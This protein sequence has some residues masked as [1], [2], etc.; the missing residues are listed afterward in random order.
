MIISFLL[1]GNGFASASDST[2][3]F[4]TGP[5]QNLPE[6]GPESF[7]AVLS[8]QDSIAIRGTMPLITDENEKSEWLKSIDNYG[9]ISIKEIEPYMIENGGP[10][11]SYGYDVNGYL[12]VAFSEESKESPDEVI[13]D[14]LY[15]I[16]NKNCMK[17]GYSENIPVLFTIEETPQL[18]SRSSIWSSLIGGIR[19]ER[20]GGVGSTL[21]FAAE[22]GSGQKGFV[23]SGHAAVNGGGVGSSIYQPYEYYAYEVGEVEDIGGT[24]SDAAWVETNA[25][26]DDIYHDDTNILKDVKDYRDPQNGWGV[27]MSGISSDKETGTVVRC[28]YTISSSTFGTLYDQYRAT[29]SSSGGDSGAPVYGSVTGGVEVYGAHWG[30][31]TSYSYFSPISGIYEDLGV[32]PLTT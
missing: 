9:R 10:L 16:I 13:I 20:E 3:D 2:D 12:V 1:I 8:N 18:D 11:L 6:F 7:E 26:L 15:D 23:M 30:H 14:E 25:V 28:V 22:D 19:I 21:S 27:Y 32:T 24:Y 29:Y 4:V 31:T 5:S 17:A